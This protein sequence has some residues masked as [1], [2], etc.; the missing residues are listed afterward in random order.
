MSE[1][2]LHQLL[3]AVDD[4]DADAVVALMTPDCRLLTVDGRRAVGVEA[5]RELFAGFLATLHS[6][7]HRITAEWHVDGVWIAEVDAVYELKED[8][9][10]IGNLPRVFVARGGPHGL[11]DV[12][13]YGAHEDRLGEH[14][15][16][17]PGLTFA[18]HW[19]PSL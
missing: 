17:A 3:R 5:V 8:R 13:V 1:S 15:G 6:T 4:L 9:L 19:M 14:R 18:G 7:A 12:R 16:S 10:R 2:P 11:T